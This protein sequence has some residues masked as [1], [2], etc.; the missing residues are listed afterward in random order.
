MTLSAIDPKPAAYQ[1]DQVLLSV[2]IP[3]F[4]ERGNVAELIAPAGRDAD[5]RSAGK[6]SSSTTIRPTVPRTR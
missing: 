1:A 5:R 2:V 3:T 4:K 6:R